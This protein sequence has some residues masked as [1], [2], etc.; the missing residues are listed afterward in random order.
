MVYS[1]NQN[2]CAFKESTKALN[3]S[4]VPM[5]SYVHT[6][7]KFTYRFEGEQRVVEHV[8]RIVYF[9]DLQKR[10]AHGTL[11][12][13]IKELHYVDGTIGSR[14][15]MYIDSEMLC[16]LMAGLDDFVMGHIF[17]PGSTPGATFAIDMGNG[18]VSSLVLKS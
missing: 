15:L 2:T 12:A 14:F 13:R 9:I 10:L 16:K 4:G 5:G 11:T 8:E 17:V 7:E 6:A 3:K 1:E 18:T